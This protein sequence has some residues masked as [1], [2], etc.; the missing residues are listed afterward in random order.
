MICTFIDKSRS[1]V[2]LSLYM[3]PKGVVQSG[4]RSKEEELL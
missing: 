2:V 4:N 1:S 3:L